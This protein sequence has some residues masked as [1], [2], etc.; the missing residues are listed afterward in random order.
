VRLGNSCS[1]FGALKTDCIIR[2]ILA[3]LAQQAHIADHLSGRL[4]VT[5]SSTRVE[6]YKKLSLTRDWIRINYA[7][8]MTLE[9]MAKVA[10]LNG[11]HLLRMFRQCYQVTPHQFLVHTRLEQARH[12]LRH[13]AE[14]VSVICRSTGFESISSFSGLFKQRYG[15]PPSLFRRQ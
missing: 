12:L 15:L 8:P 7:A 9:D 1:S 4:A 5:R 11:Q 6:L 10:M 13:S 2:D 14:G 3:D